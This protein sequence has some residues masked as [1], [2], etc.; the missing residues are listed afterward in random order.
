MCFSAGASFGASALL[1]AAGVVATSK[2]KSTPQKMLAAIPFVFAFQQLLEGLLWLSIKN[3]FPEVMHQFTRDAYLVIAMGVWPVWIP[4]NMRMFEQHK[5]RRRI[6]DIL[7]VIGMLVS[8]LTFYI[9][10]LYPVQS[11]PM[12]YHLHY[13]FDIPPG[14]REKIWIFSI[15][16]C[17]ATILPPFIS[18]NKKMRWLGIVFAVA[19]S[20]TLVFYPGA[21]VS[22]WCYF[23]AIL[24]IVIIYI[25]GFSTRLKKGLG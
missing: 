22:V 7:M 23:A 25:L 20:F 5:L 14:I 12:D 10:V 15:L 8:L 4:L 9:L 2:A 16:Y 3:A 21:V 19:Y 18:S 1:I 24:S 11:M 17:I 13:H 6:L